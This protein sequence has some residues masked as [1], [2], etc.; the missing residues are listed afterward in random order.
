VVCLW[1]EVSGAAELIPDDKL[2]ASDIPV[3]GDILL[4]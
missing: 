2:M 3:E 1:I 4:F